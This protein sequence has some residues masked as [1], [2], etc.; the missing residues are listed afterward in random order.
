MA[1]N[2]IGRWDSAT[3]AFTDFWNWQNSN[4]PTDGIKAIVKRQGTMRGGS[5]GFWCI[6]VNGNDWIHVTL[7]PA[8]YN[9]SFNNVYTMCVDTE[10]N[11]WVGSEYGLRKFPA[12]NNS[13]FT[14]Y[15]T[16]NS[17]LP[18]PYMS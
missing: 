16:S 2:G 8:G 4:L 12:G 9:Y 11:L 7:S 14:P 3:G 17:P 5:A 6:L 15:D 1:C 18:S 10:N 13:T